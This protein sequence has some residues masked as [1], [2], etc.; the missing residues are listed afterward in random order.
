MQRDLEERAIKSK[1]LLKS[2]ATLRDLIKA[3]VHCINTETR[4]TSGFLVRKKF[5]G[6]LYCPADPFFVALYFNDLL[7]TKGTLGAISDAN[8]GIR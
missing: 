1:S 5:P 4:G 6:V 7:L 3:C 2:A 8:S